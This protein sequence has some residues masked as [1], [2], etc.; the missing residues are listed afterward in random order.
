MWLYISFVFIAVL[1]IVV[2]SILFF[3]ADAVDLSKVDMQVFSSTVPAAF[4]RISSSRRY[5][6][7]LFFGA[8]ILSQFISI[9]SVIYE[10]P[11][12]LA[13]YSLLTVVVLF[14]GAVS[15][16]YFLYFFRLLIDIIGLFIAFMIRARF[17]VN[18]AVINLRNR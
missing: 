10:S 18:Y 4:S 12:L 1:N 8:T 6:E 16:P 3:E 9:L 15:V 7:F 2:T 5:S 11:F 14:W 17:I 13:L